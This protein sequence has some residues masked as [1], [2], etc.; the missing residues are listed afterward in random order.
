MI[1]TGEAQEPAARRL[2]A[3]DAYDPDWPATVLSDCA[4]PDAPDRPGA[5][6]LLPTTP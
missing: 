5:A 1:V 4:D 3:A 2:A 6:A